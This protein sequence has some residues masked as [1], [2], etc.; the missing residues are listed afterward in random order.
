MTFRLINL[1]ILI[2]SIFSQYVE[3]ELLLVKN[4]HSNQV[5]ILNYFI[6][7]SLADH[8]ISKME[9]EHH[10]FCSKKL[11]TNE[12]MYRNFIHQYTKLT[13][14]NQRDSQIHFILCNCFFFLHIIIKYR[15][16]SSNDIVDHSTDWFNFLLVQSSERI[17]IHS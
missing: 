16:I 3:L 15:L 5:F 6:S 11:K 4:E 9:E 7:F 13:N 10:H 14:K 2:F 8:D 1:S 17:L 12:A